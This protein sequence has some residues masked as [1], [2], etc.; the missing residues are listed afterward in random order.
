VPPAPFA[1]L[2][3]RTSSESLAGWWLTGDRDALDA[4]VATRLDLLDQPGFGNRR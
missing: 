3:A 1:A 4:L 2:I